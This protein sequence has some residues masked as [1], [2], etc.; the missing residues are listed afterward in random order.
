MH[1]HIATDRAANLRGS[2]WMI[3]SMAAFAVEDALLKGAAQSLPISEVLIL[4]GCG[5][6]LVFAGAA[7]L[8]GTPLLSAAALS[9]PMRLRAVFEVV[10][11]LFYMIAIALLPLSTATVILQATPLV[12][13]AGA[14]LLFRETVGWRRWLAIAA[15]LA[16]VVVILQPGAE[17]FSPLSLV[18]V[19][20]MLGFAGR[21]LASRAAPAGLSTAALGFYG[22]LALIVAGGG[23]AVWEG[24]AFAL[25]GARATLFLLAAILCGTAAYASLMKAMRTGEVSAVTPFRYSRLIFGVALGIVVFGERLTP[26]MLLGSALI[27]ASGLFILWRG[28]AASA[29]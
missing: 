18:A 26:Q 2:A 4:F 28:R 6:A 22:L 27:V 25:P 19:V 7:A 23:Y 20:G 3:A 13:V 21:D 14:A 15:G 9:R 17:S 5:G 11:R 1:S 29:G 24:A 10:G 8:G 12:V 16:G